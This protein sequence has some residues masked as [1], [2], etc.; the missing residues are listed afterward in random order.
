MALSTSAC[1]SPMGRA[2]TPPRWPYLLPLHHVQKVS[3]GRLLGVVEGQQGQRAL[4]LRQ[5]LTALLPLLCQLG[6]RKLQ[7]CFG[8]PLPDQLDQVLLLVRDKVDG[9]QGAARPNGI[10]KGTL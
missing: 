1:Q 2:G 5:A 10:P 8:L 6:L 9:S 3:E 7:C 4:H